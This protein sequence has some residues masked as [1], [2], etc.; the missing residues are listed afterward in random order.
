MQENKQSNLVPLIL[1]AVASVILIVII[2][3]GIVQSTKNSDTNANGSSGSSSSTAQS[4]AITV[5]EG[6]SLP[7]AQYNLV[8][9]L[10]NN[11]Q[12]N[13]YT[14]IQALRDT[15]SNFTFTTKD[16][17]NLGPSITSVNGV[18]PTSTQFWKIVVNGSDA[19]VGI[20]SL[21]L[22]PGDKLSFVLTEIQQ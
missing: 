2:V 16:Y 6:T 21:M 3:L 20:G 4:I 11:G 13:A 5:Q 12:E 22:K 1:S 17:P 15:T 18:E 14:F 9:T 19:Q 7:E 8:P 10:D